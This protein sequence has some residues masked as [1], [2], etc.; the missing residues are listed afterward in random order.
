MA[1]GTLVQKI[2]DAHYVSGEKIPGKPVAI[3]IDQT[4]TQDATGTMAYL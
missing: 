4:L 2:I 3:R 1:H